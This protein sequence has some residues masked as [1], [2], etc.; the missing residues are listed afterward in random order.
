[1]SET[2]KLKKE[3]ERLKMM[4]EIYKRQ[5]RDYKF[6][7]HEIRKSIQGVIRWLELSPER[8]I[9]PED[10]A[11]MMRKNYEEPKETIFTL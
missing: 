8:L 1:M 10:M 4:A 9:Q 2:E 5:I 11:R 6:E 3:N 7:L